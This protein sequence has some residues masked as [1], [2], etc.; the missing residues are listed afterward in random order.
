[1]VWLRRSVWPSVLGWKAVDIRVRMPESLRNSF[2]TSEVKRE[3]RSDTM[4]DGSPWCRQISHAK[5]LARS[6][7]VLPSFGRGRKCAILVYQ[8]TITQSW[9]HPSEIGKSVI[10]SMAIDYH[11]S[12]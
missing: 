12:E 2:H 1:M 4:S 9:S 8:S 5:I 3:S 6:L 7:A 11:V 10:K